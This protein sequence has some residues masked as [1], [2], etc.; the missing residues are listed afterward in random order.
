MDSRSISFL[1]QLLEY[2]EQERTSNFAF[3]GGIQ[4]EVPSMYTSMHEGEVES[5]QERAGG[6]WG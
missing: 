1:A 2:I 4:W 6:G 5:Y 3:L